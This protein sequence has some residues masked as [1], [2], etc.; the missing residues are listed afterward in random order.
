MPAWNLF[1][2]GMEGK[3]MTFVQE[4]EPEVSTYSLWGRELRLQLCPYIS[5][6]SRHIIIL[7]FYA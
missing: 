4:R 6:K 7:F 3:T 2:K 1:V 5:V